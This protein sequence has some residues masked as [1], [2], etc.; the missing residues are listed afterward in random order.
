MNANDVSP[1]LA[2]AIAELI[3][4][5]EMMNLDISEIMNMKLGDFTV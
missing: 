2:K 1:L 5:Y 4:F 3:D